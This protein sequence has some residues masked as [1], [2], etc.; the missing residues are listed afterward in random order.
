VSERIRLPE[1]DSSTQSRILIIGTAVFL[2][3][4]IA[5]SLPKGLWS[6]RHDTAAISASPF[7]PRT[8]KESSMAA[9][10]QFTPFINSL[11]MSFVPV[12][13]A[14]GPS[15]GQLVMFSLWETRVGDYAVYAKERGIN[16]VR[17]NFMQTDDHPVVNVSWHDAQSFCDWLTQK[18][19]AA[20]SIPA[21]ARYRLPSDHEWSCAASIGEKEDAAQPPAV[22]TMVIRD[23]PW[24]S[25]EIPPAN[26]G[27]YHPSLGLENH[28]GT[29]PVTHFT[30]NRLGL[31]SIGG[32]VSEWCDDWYDEPR[33]QRVLRGASWLESS[34]PQLRL[35]CRFQADPNAR[36]PNTGFRMVLAVGE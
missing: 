1:I 35:S 33:H 21:T 16:P 7:T 28:I 27:N 25:A 2:P 10:T 11:G 8:A 34:L 20:G 23:L 29:A 3:T 15:A 19:R 24:G 4:V 32:N 13:V 6:R 12:R 5:M 18:E 17:P 22:K 36:F 14:A 31:H 30:S 26:A 9:A